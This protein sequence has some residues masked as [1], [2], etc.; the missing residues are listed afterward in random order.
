VGVLNLHARARVVP[1][2]RT[3]GS[4]PWASLAPLAS[5]L[6]PFLFVR[7]LLKSRPRRRAA[8]LETKAHAPT[9][10]AEARVC[11]PLP[12]YLPSSRPRPVPHCPLSF[13]PRSSSLLVF[14]PSPPSLSLSLFLPLY[15]YAFCDLFVSASRPIFDFFLS[16]S[17]SLPLSLSLSLSLSH[18]HSFLLLPPIS[19]ASSLTTQFLG[20]VVGLARHALPHTRIRRCTPPRANSPPHGREREREG[21]EGREGEKGQGRR[22]REITRGGALHLHTRA[23]VLSTSSALSKG[24]SAPPL[25]RSH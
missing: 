19:P 14:L 6:S 10:D 11:S 20:G 9:A 13:V 24:S 16:V 22:A 2:K 8:R 21:R 18:S 4:R 12:C 15:Y 17:P 23:D 7:P 3:S 1:A 25:N 5:H